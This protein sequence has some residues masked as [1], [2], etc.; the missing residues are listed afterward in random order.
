MGYLVHFLSYLT[1]FSYLTNFIGLNIRENSVVRDK[2][3]HLFLTLGL[4]S[5]LLILLLLLKSGIVLEASRVSFSLNP[6]WILMF[7]SLLIMFAYMLSEE[8]SPYH[9]K[10]FYSVSFFLLIVSM[11]GFHFSEAGGTYLLRPLLTF[12]ILVS[13]LAQVGVYLVFCF[14]LLL[15]L[16]NKLL[17]NKSRALGKLPSLVPTL[18]VLHSAEYISICFLTLS[19]ISGMF[20]TD[21]IFTEFNYKFLFSFLF[22]FALLMSLILRKILKMNSIKVCNYSAF[23]WTILL[24][25]QIAY[26]L[27]LHL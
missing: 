19:I 26:K 18:K 13:I 11:L 16:L 5:Q 24:L 8:G 2:L 7:C 14:T 15:I 3:F 1:L 10:I 17:R 22:F 27:K 21:Q 25:M 12:H 6:F 9:T 23:I 4:I 20:I